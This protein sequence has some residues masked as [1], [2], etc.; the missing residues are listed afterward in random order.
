[1]PGLARR[2]GQRV[3]FVGHRLLI[4]GPAGQLLLLL[5]NPVLAKYGL[6]ISTAFLADH[7]RSKQVVSGL[8]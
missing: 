7:L 2:L 5:T 3:G 6:M 1:M 4:T 8:I